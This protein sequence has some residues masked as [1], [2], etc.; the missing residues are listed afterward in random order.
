VLPELCLDEPAHLPRLQREQGIGKRRDVGLAS[1]PAKLPALALRTRIVR[2]L[3]RELCE[4]LSGLHASE[5]LAGAP[6]RCGAVAARF[7]Q[8]VPRA[9]LL[10]DGVALRRDLVVIPV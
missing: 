6:L 4:I 10:G 3:T 7:D 5:Q 2:V 8:D 9:P 1:G